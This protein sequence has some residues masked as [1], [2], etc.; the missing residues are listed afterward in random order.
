MEYL[1][2]PKNMG[3]VNRFFVAN[4]LSELREYSGRNI[5]P[6]SNMDGEI[7]TNLEYSEIR[8]RKRVRK[9]RK[10]VKS[11]KNWEKVLEY[12][13]IGMAK[14]GVDSLTSEEAKSRRLK[15][16]EL[17]QGRKERR[18]SI[19]EKQADTQQEL[20]KTM[21]QPSAT[22]EAL[23]KALTETPPTTMDT[24]KSVPTAVDTTTSGMSKKTKTILIVSGV[25]VV[26][27]AT[28]LIIRK[29]RKK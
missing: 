5:S 9:K 25:V 20:A 3:K 12:T 15:R 27:T 6:F 29:M 10:P 8:G 13:P 23:T 26:L 24:T 2:S 18:L 11:K 22:D 1:N 17:R 7:N 28:I 21:N 16:Q 4:G 19:K 14:K